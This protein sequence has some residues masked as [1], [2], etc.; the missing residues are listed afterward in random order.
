MS[1]IEDRLQWVE[2]RWAINDLIVKYSV[3]TDDRDIDTL[4]DLYTEDAVFEGSSGVI[5]GR[6]AIADFYRER[7]AIQGPSFHIP[8]SQE[9]HRISTTE[10]R[11]VTLGAV[12]MAL[13]GKAFWIAMRYLDH[14]IKGVDGKWRFRERE[15]RQYYAMPFDELSEGMASELRKRWPGAAP[16]PADIP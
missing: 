4:A 13:E 14:Y 11:G 8:Y 15:M 5:R 12:E 16:Q 9:V 1:E 3:A 6:E 10:A 2:D 7:T